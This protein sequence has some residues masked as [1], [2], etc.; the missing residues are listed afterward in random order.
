MYSLKNPRK[1]KT[2]KGT[3]Y[4]IIKFSDLNSVFELFV[5]SDIFENNREILIEGN[6]V[7]ITLAKNY[8]DE[9]KIQKKINIRKLI[10]MKE[11]INKPIDEIKIKIKNIDDIKK[12]NKL[13]SEEG[14]T[15]VII[16]VEVD[17]KRVFFQLKEKRKIDHKMLNLIRNYKNI[18][19][20]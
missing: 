19:V 14:K 20:I 9:S 1:K 10:S 6:S 3:S 17:K 13:I 11:V 12:I 15:K 4:A 8:V 5:F 16:D 7:M 2:Q 18:D